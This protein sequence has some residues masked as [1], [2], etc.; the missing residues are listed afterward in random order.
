MFR[1]E[2]YF[3]RQQ[4]AFEAVEDKV[5]SAEPASLV[6]DHDLVHASGTYSSVVGDP[7]FGISLDHAIKLNRHTQYCQW[8]EYSRTKCDTCTRKRKGKT[9]RYDC[10][11][12]ETYHYVKAWRNHRVSSFIFKQPANHHNPQRDPFPS[13]S[14]VSQSV[15][16][17]SYNVLPE[18]SSAVRG[19]SRSVAWTFNKNPMPRTFFQN[20]FDGLFGAPPPTRWEDVGS[21]L[22][23]TMGSIATYEHKFLYTNTAEGWFFSAYTAPT[24]QKL[25][26]GFGQYLEGSLFDWQIGDLYDLYNGCTAGDIR[27][28]FSVVDPRTISVI[29]EAR[30]GQQGQGARAQVGSFHV[31]AV[32]FDVG[33]MHAGEHS[34]QDMFENETKEAYGDAWYKRFFA[35]VSGLAVA[36]LMRK[37]AG[38]PEPNNGGA[39][40]TATAGLSLC[41]LFGVWAAAYGLDDWSGADTS[42]ETVIVGIAGLFLFAAS[43]FMHRGSHNK[44][45]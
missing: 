30:K 26:R 15:S 43:M 10:N 9:E 20:I 41:I 25:L 39:F 36:Y 14:T 29:G 37:Y 21:G 17:G 42:K 13:M 1:S 7:A 24:W 27:V 31:S 18:V 38:M 2:D 40:L 5:V 23:N 19:V 28:R 33:I 3:R 45:L 4:L 22:A 32:N 8:Q 16:L 44:S 35:I 6:R 11:C 34:A 12:R